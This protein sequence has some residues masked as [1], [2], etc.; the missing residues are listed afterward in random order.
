MESAKE[1]LLMAVTVLG[2]AFISVVIAFCAAWISVAIVEVK[3]PEIE[4]DEEV[5]LEK[6]NNN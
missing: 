3:C 4:M 2:I 6:Y 1:I 5:E